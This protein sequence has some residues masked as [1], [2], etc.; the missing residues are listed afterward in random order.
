MRTAHDRISIG[1]QMNLKKISFDCVCVPLEIEK[2]TRQIKYFVP[3][4]LFLSPSSSH[5][6]YLNQRTN[7]NE[8]SKFVRL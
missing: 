5:P 2:K 4:F 6:L 1:R 3:F 7:L 8:I